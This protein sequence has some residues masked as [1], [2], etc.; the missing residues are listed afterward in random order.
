MTKR[1][2][3]GN[4]SYQTTETTLSDLFGEI[5]E[6]ASVSLVTD[7]MTGRSRGF[8]FIEMTDESAAQRAIAEL[9]GKT[10]D[11]RD[12]KVAEAR[13]KRERKSRDSWGGRD[14]GRY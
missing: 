10:V 4:L 14:R 6:V 13:P 3:V 2:Y 8:A 7:R 11:E 9:N 12:L 5:G 1:L